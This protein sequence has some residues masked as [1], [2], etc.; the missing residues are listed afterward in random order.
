MLLPQEL[1]LLHDLLPFVL[2]H[3]IVQARYC[4]TV[5]LC[6]ERRNCPLD[7]SYLLYQLLLSDIST[8][9]TFHHC[10][11]SI[12]WQFFGFAIPLSSVNKIATTAATM[13]NRFL[14]FP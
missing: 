4:Y 14:L 2:A 1:N 12:R 9:H 10:C 13:C 8:R 6:R 5:G 7:L 3:L 11:F